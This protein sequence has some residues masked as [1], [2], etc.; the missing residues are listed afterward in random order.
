M[1]TAQTAASGFVAQLRPEDQAAGHRLRQPGHA[2]RSRS[3]ATR[4]TS[5]RR[6]ASTV[7]GGSTALYNADLHRPQGTE[8]GAGPRRRRPPPPGHRRAVGRRGHVEPRVVRRSARTGETVRDRDLR[9]RP[10]VEGATCTARATTRR[11]SSL[12]QLT[13]Q[14]GG[15][16]FFPATADE[17]PAIYRLI[18]EELS[19]QYLLGYTS[20]NPKRDGRWRR[21][22]VRGEPH[23]ARTARTKQGYY[24][25]GG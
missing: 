4:P 24:A 11:T 15:R 17:L 7:P 13:T 14:T 12:R 10:Q 3:P 21:I 6:S 25:P 22:E 16:V 19:S 23:P 5:R 1:A 9:H 18:S 2:S 20:R 8:E